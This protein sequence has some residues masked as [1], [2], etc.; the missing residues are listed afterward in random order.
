MIVVNRELIKTVIERA[1]DGLPPQNVLLV[2]VFVNGYMYDG[3]AEKQLYHALM[4]CDDLQNSYLAH[5]IVSA[6]CEEH[7]IQWDICRVIRATHYPNGSSEGQFVIEA[8]V[9]PRVD[10][11]D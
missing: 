3:E 7:G 8:I 10:E 9:T 2:T 6:Y 11:E 4:R 1:S 5:G